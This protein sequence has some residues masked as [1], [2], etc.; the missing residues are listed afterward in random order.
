MAIVEINWRP[1]HRDLRLFAAIQ[2][3]AA[4]IVSVSLGT[5]IIVFSGV[6]LLAGQVRPELMRWP[7]LVWMIG[8]FPVGWVMSHVL[9]AVVYFGIITPVGLILRAGGHDPLRLR[10]VE[11]STFWINRPEARSPSDYFRQY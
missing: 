4:L 9:L 8:A 5:G 1:S 6:G 7:Y 10:K 11:S 2:L 3:V